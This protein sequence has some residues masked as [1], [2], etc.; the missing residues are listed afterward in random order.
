MKKLRNGFFVTL[1]LTAVLLTVG[2]IGAGM[3]GTSGHRNGQSSPTASSP[4][5]VLGPFSG[6]PDA[7][8]TGAPVPKVTGSTSAYLSPLTTLTQRVWI[9]WLARNWVSQSPK[10]R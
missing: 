8:T 5:P 6:E 4:R 2:G 7:G 10:S 3:A 1:V 9:I